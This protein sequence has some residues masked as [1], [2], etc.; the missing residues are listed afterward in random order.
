MGVT[1]TSPAQSCQA[2]DIGPHL[3]YQYRLW[4]A[5]GKRAIVGRVRV[6]DVLLVYWKVPA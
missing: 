2:F 4:I 1:F 3:F 6:R 5:R